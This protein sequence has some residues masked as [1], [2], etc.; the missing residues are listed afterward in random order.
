MAEEVLAIAQEGCLIEERHGE[1]A[2]QLRVRGDLLGELALKAA[3][4]SA[5][6][7]KSVYGEELGG[8]RSEEAI[9]QD[10]QKRALGSAS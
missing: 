8:A 1:R 3:I 9:H 4:A 6:V 7:A 5:V 2:H 10:D